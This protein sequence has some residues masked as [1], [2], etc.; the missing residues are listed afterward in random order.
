M[1]SYGR[2]V[3]NVKTNFSILNERG[4]ARLVCTPFI[5]VGAS[6]EVGVTSLVWRILEAC[7]WRLI[8][9]VGGYN[10]SDREGLHHTLTLFLMMLEM[11]VI[12]PGQ[13]LLLVSLFHVMR[14]TI[15]SARIRAH[16]AKA[17]ETM[18]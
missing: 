11:A 2:L 3:L 16:H 6:L 13:G 14:I 18:L 7:S 9:F 15:M 17:W 10:A 5:L 8:I 4:T 1:S 12:G